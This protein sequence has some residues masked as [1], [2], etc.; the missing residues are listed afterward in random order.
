MA[1]LPPRDSSL[2][3]TSALGVKVQLDEV[4]PFDGEPPPSNPAR[5]T[6]EQYA[7]LS[8]ELAREPDQASATLARYGITGEAAHRS[9]EQAIL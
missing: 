3:E 6:L 4:L 7:S 2:D 5:L 8:A 9:Q 1:E